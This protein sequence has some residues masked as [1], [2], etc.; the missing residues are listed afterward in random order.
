MKSAVLLTIF[1]IQNA[2]S[3]LQTYALQ[4][5]I[6][7]VAGWDCKAIDIAPDLSDKL[8]S[9]RTIGSKKTFWAKCFDWVAH[10]WRVTR[11]YGWISYVDKFREKHDRAC[12]YP[13]IADE[14]KAFVRDEICTTRL[15]SSESD[16][17][18]DI[19]VGNLYITGADQTFNPRYT[20][21]SSLWFFGFLRGLT[22]A[23]YRKIS[24]ASSMGSGNLPA[25]HWAAYAQAFKDYDG[26]SFREQ[27]S[28]SLAAE[29]GVSAVLCCDPTML[30]TR[31]EWRSFADKATVKMRGKYILCYDLEYLTDPWPTNIRI[32]S[33]LK[34]RLG[35]PIVYMKPGYI[36]MS[37]FGKWQRTIISVYDFV[38]L[39]LNASFIATSSYHGTVFSLLS[40]NPFLSY[41]K[42]DAREDGR[43]MDL[44]RRC[45]AT[46][47]AVEI[48]SA[49]KLREDIRSY[50]GT[51]EEQSEVD[52]FRRASYAWLYDQIRACEIWQ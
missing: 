4:R 19:P 28:V 20:A 39:F 35:L 48:S 40:G 23:S 9:A 50:D 2:G 14:F 45:K 15:Y 38:W 41:V 24:Y 52:S 37:G 10:K 51:T 12:F 21:G 5:V 49:T 42:A 1:R 18:S 6:K 13:R 43:V 34:K 36:Y 17:R 31:E 22:R 32:E 29:M 46:A 8:S 25:H 30:L 3:V 11:K 44:L 26:L 33:A 7:G 47:H 16:L 27:T